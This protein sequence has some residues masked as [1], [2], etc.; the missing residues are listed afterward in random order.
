M[1]KSITFTFVASHSSEWV[2]VF[3]CCYQQPVVTYVLLSWCLNN[4][5]RFCGAESLTLENQEKLWKTCATS[6]SAYSKQ[7]WRKEKKT[8]EK[9]QPLHLNESRS[10]H[11]L[12]AAYWSLIESLVS[13]AC[14]PRLLN[15]RG[16][17][18]FD[19]TIRFYRSENPFYKPYQSTCPFCSRRLKAPAP[20]LRA[21][22]NGRRS[23]AD[24]RSLAV[25]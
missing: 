3:A 11:P 4:S 6:A 22:H 24:T 15:A 19:E 14:I 10:H 12:I 8:K 18:R 2:V 25:L 23:L 13:F 9:R 20:G 21:N 5:W 7:M 17:S 1:C 16:T